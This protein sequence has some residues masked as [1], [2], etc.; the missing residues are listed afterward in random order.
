MAAAQIFDD[1]S[2][3]VD[4]ALDFIEHEVGCNDFVTNW[5]QWKSA[6]DPVARVQ[7]WLKSTGTRGASAES[8]ILAIDELAKR[9]TA[10][11]TP[12]N[13]RLPQ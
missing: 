13:R 5:P 7:E 11:L 9:G 1:V 8:I 2:R 4:L 10:W 3:E 6:A 12:Y